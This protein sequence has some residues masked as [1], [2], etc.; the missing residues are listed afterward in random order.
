VDWFLDRFRTSINVW[1]D[2]VGAAVLDRYLREP[3]T[4]AVENDGTYLC[5]KEPLT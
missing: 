3:T 5:R 2:A 1:G 4:E